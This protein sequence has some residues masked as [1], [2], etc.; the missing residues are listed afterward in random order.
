MAL[1][2]RELRDVGC[3][4]DVVLDGPA[5]LVLVEVKLGAPLGA[6]PMQ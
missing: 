3:E 4:P 2:D 6:D 1:G 5:A